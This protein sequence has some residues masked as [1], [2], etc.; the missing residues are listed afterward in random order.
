MCGF[1][2]TISK[3]E[4]SRSKFLEANK[5]ISSRGPDQT[6]RLSFQK[7]QYRLGV[8]YS[9]KEILML[10][11]GYVAEDGIMNSKK[12]AEENSLDNYRTTALRGPSAGFTLELPMGNGSTFGLDYSYR[13][14]NPFQGSHSIGA[15]INL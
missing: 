12:S 5:F 14:T 9:Y 2:T 11:G 3:E 13:H 15:R 8:E 10:R 7:D 4:I 6:N 1:I